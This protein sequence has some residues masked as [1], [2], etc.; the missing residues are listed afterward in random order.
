MSGPFS[1]IKVGDYIKLT[2]HTFHS[3]TKT[4]TRKVT[5]KGQL[6]LGVNMFGYTPYYLMRIDKWKK[7]DPPKKKMK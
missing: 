3:G 7:V 5:Y 1:K 4:V 6:G 2:T